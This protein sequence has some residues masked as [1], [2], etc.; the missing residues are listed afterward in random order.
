MAQFLTPIRAMRWLQQ[1]HMLR[2]LHLF[3][4]SCNLLNQDDQLISIVSPSIGLGP[5][6]LIIPEFA[7]E[8]VHHG[9]PIRVVDGRLEIGNWGLGIDGLTVWDA[10]PK[11]GQLKGRVFENGRLFPLAP[12]IQYHFDRLLSGLKSESETIV[13]DA[14]YSLAGLG[15]GLTPTG[16]DIL[17]GAIYALWVYQPHSEWI[18]LIGETAVPRTTTLSAAFLRAAMDGE[19][20]IHWHQLVQNHP[21]AI[22]K[23]LSIGHTSGRDA[24]TGFLQ[25]I[26]LLKTG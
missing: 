16:D 4:N 12:K 1:T 10:V 2:I 8:K 22:Q 14:A 7:L 5:F 20:T 18:R 23:I 3:A 15:E 26:K 13:I 25:T 6:S 17:M 11:W 21:H 24:W 9:E 19:A